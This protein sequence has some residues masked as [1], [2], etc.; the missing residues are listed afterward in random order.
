MKDLNIMIIDDHSIVREGI[1]SSLRSIGNIR[2]IA[3]AKNGS[4]AI[5]I[6][7]KKRNIDIVITDI[8]ME[9]IDGIECTRMIKEI[10]PDIKVLAFSMLS[11]PSDIQEILKAGAKGYILKGEGKKELLEAIQ[12]ISEGKTY[13]SKEV[14]DIIMNALMNEERSL[15]DQPIST[16]ELTEREKHILQLIIKQYSNKQIAEELFISHRTVEAHKRNIMQ[17]TKSKNAAGIMTYAIRKKLIKDI[18]L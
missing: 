17:K 14:A 15:A 16:E 7:K 4:E 3:N 5:E 11:K 10:N 18:D 2:V 1:A 9:G 8:N 6:I 13:Y 12:A